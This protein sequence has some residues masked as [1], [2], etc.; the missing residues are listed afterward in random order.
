MAQLWKFRER[1]HQYSL[2]NYGMAA[3]PKTVYIFE[4]FNAIQDKKDFCKVHL[5]IH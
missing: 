3:I 4:Y 5:Q 2:Q 1:T